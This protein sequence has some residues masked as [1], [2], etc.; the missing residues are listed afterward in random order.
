MGTLL[1]RSPVEILELL[2]AEATWY[3]SAIELDG[4]HV[5]GEDLRVEAEQSVTI[6]AAN[7][8]PVPPAPAEPPILTDDIPVDIRADIGRILDECLGD[9]D[10]AAQSAEFQSGY[11]RGF[12]EAVV[13]FCK[14]ASSDSPP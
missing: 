11:R 8:K 5:D 4:Y 12:T 1:P 13:V 2:L 7:H 10:L 14:F 6:Y 3:C 9:P